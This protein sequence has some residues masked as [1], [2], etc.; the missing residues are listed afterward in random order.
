MFFSCVPPGCTQTTQCL[1]DTNSTIKRGNAAIK[2]DK[3]KQ[4]K[5]RRKQYKF[6]KIKKEFADVLLDGKYINMFLGL[7]DIMYVGENSGM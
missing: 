2:E 7:K 4:S 5:C 6:H 3:K 1:L